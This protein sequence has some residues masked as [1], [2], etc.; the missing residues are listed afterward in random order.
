MSK[1]PK[2]DGRCR[3]TAMG[4]MPHTDI[5]RALQLA[6]SLDIPF[7]PQLPR[8]SFYEDMYAQ[9]SQF[10]P[11]I[12]V[13]PAGE[14]VLFNSG[15]FENGIAGYETTLQ[16]PQ[17]LGLT[18]EYSTVYHRFLDRDL[19]RYYSIRGQMTGPVSFGFRIIDEDNKPIIYNDSVKTILFDFMQRKVNIQVEQ[20]R[21]RNPR[22]FVWLDEP[23]LGWVFSGF[24]GYAD[25]AA[26]EDYQTFMAGI[27]GLK[28]L[29]LCAT[30]NLPYLL[31]LGIEVLSFDAYQIESMP[32]GYV[33]AVGDYLRDGNIIAWGIVP[34][35]STSLERETPESLAARLAGYWDRV[36]AGT[37]IEGRQIAEQS[38]IAPARCCLKNTGKVGSAGESPAPA[39]A[40]PGMGTVEEALVEKAFGYL[41]QV[42]E[43]L[44]EK[45]RV[46]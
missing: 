4:I 39:C 6:L 35:D 22:A 44:R 40:A 19:S 12:K 15:D 26:R 33:G 18:R 7:W 23:G 17:G 43:M 32:Q 28:A 5:E 10:F 1:E 34:T 46:R 13:D 20:L 41:P 45:Y 37:G 25:V 29:H 16:D 30:I 14:K 36:T 9:A 38:L 24:T 11:G 31:S 8:V 27:E 42:A 2:L 3:T 21:A